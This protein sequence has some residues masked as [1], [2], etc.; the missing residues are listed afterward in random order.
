V[1]ANDR[2]ADPTPYKD[3]KNKQ[4]HLVRT[5]E[6]LIDKFLDVPEPLDHSQRAPF[7]WNIT[8]VEDAFEN[9]IK[10]QAGENQCL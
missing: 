9:R 3:I 10:Q 4:I 6:E 5:F 1:A 8:N 2:L 7:A